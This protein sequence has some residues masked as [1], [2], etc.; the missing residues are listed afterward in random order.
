MSSRHMPYFNL[1]EPWLVL[2]RCL[3][4]AWINA[5]GAA[6]LLVITNRRVLVIPDP[7]DR[8]A[9][10][11]DLTI[12]AAAISSFVYCSTLLKAY[13]KLFIPI[14]KGL[15]EVTIQFGSTLAGMDD[16]FG[17]LRQVLATTAPI[18]FTPF[19]T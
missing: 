15:D 1:L 3:L 16:C 13:L 14:P 8:A 2:A 4:P 17:V 18:S 12:P 9:E 19:P 7:S 6:S 5:R 11:L 10:R